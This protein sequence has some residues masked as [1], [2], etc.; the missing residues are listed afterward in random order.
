MGEVK[1]RRTS[2]YFEFCVRRDLSVPQGSVTN[3]IV[4]NK[5]LNPLA[6]PGYRGG[7]ATGEYLGTPGTAAQ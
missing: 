3:K 4:R 7:I 1:Y 5:K 2:R 6:V